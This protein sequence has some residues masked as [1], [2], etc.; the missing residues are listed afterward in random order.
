[1]GWYGD[2]DALD[3]LAV[4]AEPSTVILIRRGLDD[5]AVRPP[6]PARSRPA[7][8]RPASARPPS[9][10]VSPLRTRAGTLPT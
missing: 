8:A 5:P 10:A 3:D 9:G 2:P 6:W 1:M 4:T 7:R